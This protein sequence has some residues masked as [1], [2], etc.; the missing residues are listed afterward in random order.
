MG[1]W[2]TEGSE[3][4]RREQTRM[5]QA[6]VPVPVPVGDMAGLGDMAAADN[7]SLPIGLRMTMVHGQDFAGVSSLRA[8]PRRE[9][10]W[11]GS[12]LGDVTTL[13]A[14][15]LERYACFNPEKSLAGGDSRP[16]HMQSSAVLGLTPVGGDA[17]IASCTKDLISLHDVGGF[18][19]MARK[20]SALKCKPQTLQGKGKKTKTL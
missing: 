19:R 12:S 1:L 5:Q 2:D 15:T 11:V 4:V 20:I 18:T 3:G 10:I 8:D 7:T 9:M 6:P 13:H 17:C 16:Y 14:E